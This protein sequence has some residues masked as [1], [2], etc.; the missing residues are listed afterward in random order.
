MFC[1]HFMFGVGRSDRRG[2]EVMSQSEYEAAV[3][4]FI[5]TRGITRC[6]TACVVKTQ[7]MV[8]LADR[9]A[10]Q[11]RAAEFERLR[12]RRRLREPRFGAEE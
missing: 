2:V 12:L 8:S 10:L 9:E 6:P 4:D 5:R 3:K 1:T 11:Q 7:G